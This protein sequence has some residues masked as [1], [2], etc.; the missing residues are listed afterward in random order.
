[1]KD[2]INEVVEWN[3]IAWNLENPFNEQLEVAML[4]EEFAETIIAIKEE[5]IIEQIDWIIDTFIVGIWTLAKQWI[6]AEE[7]NNCFEEIIRSNNS[8]FVD[9]KAIKKNW[10]IKK[11]ESFS[12]ANLELIIYKW[13]E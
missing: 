9:W 10:K 6:T 3:K 2:L 11:P 12:E 5:D 8:K 13:K 1:M 7:I 4:S